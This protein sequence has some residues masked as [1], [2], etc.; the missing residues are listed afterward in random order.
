LDL[1]RLHMDPIISA[2]SAA[3]AGALGDCARDRD[4]PR[5]NGVTRG[6]DSHFGCMAMFQRGIGSAEFP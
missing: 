3:G 1:C 6:K 4:W 2:G 5:E